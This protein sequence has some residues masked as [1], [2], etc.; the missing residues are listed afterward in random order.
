VLAVDPNT[1]A[2]ALKE[3][4]LENIAASSL[5]EETVKRVKEYVKNWSIS[6]VTHHFPS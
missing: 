2:K 5:S 6:E 4:I 1:T 3:R